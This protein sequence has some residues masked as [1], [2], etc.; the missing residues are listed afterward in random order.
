MD[1]WSTR[2]M[3]KRTEGIEGM[4][5]HVMEDSR[6]ALT[7]QVSMARKYMHKREEDEP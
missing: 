4:Y 6:N 2:S 5:S 7:L 1:R 3:K